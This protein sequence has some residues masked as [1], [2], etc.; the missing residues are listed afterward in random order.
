[1]SSDKSDGDALS[2]K[3]KNLEQVKKDCSSLWTHSSH[4]VGEEEKMTDSLEKDDILTWEEELAEDDENIGVFFWEGTEKVEGEILKNNRKLAVYL[5]KEIVKKWIINPAKWRNKQIIDLLVERSAI[6]ANNKESVVL[7]QKK[8]IEIDET[9][10]KKTRGIAKI[11]QLNN[12]SLYLFLVPASSSIIS[13][14]GKN[15]EVGEKYVPIAELTEKVFELLWC[16][17]D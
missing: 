7:L 8:Y 4:N 13:I 15:M 14:L 10:K 1:M 5:V 17:L 12:H 9:I 6:I 16:N 11:L 3:T 2:F